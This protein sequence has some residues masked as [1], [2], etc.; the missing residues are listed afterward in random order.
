[1]IQNISAIHLHM[2]LVPKYKDGD[3]W[4]GT[5]QM[6]PGKIFLTDE[7]YSELANAIIKNLD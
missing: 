7:E 1:M 5:F 6:N 4:G 3:E 2:H